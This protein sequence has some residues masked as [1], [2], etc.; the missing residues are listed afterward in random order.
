[1][2]GATQELRLRIG[3]LLKARATARIGFTRDEK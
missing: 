2:L 3:L 1:M